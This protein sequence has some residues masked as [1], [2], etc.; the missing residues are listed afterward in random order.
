MI[1]RW[2]KWQVGD[3]AWRISVRETVQ[4]RYTHPN[5]NCTFYIEFQWRM[6]S[7]WCLNRLSNH[8]WLLQVPDT[9]IGSFIWSIV[10]SLQEGLIL[11]WISMKNVVFRKWT[12]GSNSWNT[13][14]YPLFDGG[15]QV[16]WDANL[17]SHLTFSR[18]GQVDYCIVPNK[19]ACLNKCAPSIFIIFHSK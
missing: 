17:V 18:C 14:L 12:V 1:Y 9:R 11:H 13:N 2:F 15:R 16:W 7:L 3:Y 10:I 6:K 19:C 4:N 8:G 5:S